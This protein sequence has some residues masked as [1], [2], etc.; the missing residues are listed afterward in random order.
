MSWPAV[1]TGRARRWHFLLRVSWHGA[2]YFFASEALSPSG[3]S[4]HLPSLAV[5]AY[6]ETFQFLSQSVDRQSVP[7]SVLW[8]GN[9]AAA[10]AA[11]FRL[12]T[13]EAELSVW[14]EGTA[15][16]S[17]RVLLVGRVMQPTY[18]APAEPVRFSIEAPPW[19]DQGTW[20]DLLSS[21][22]S[23]D[24]NFVSQ[25]LGSTSVGTRT[26]VLADLSGKTAPLVVG[27]PGN[28]NQ[29]RRTNPSSVFASQAP[30]IFG[31][32]RPGSFTS[33]T[34]GSVFESNGV[35]ALGNPA[36][37]F[38]TLLVLC[39]HATQAGAN[40]GDGTQKVRGSIGLE[41]APIAVLFNSDGQYVTGLVPHHATIGGRVCTVVNLYD[42]RNTRAEVRYNESGYPISTGSGQIT[43]L[44][45][46]NATSA[47]PAR[48]LGDQVGFTFVSAHDSH[49]TFYGLADP[50]SAGPLLYVQQLLGLVLSSSSLPVDWPRLFAALDRIPS[51]GVEGYI[52]ERVGV[53]EFVSR[54]L[55]PL[56]PMSLRTGPRGLYALTADLTATV[57]DTIGTLRAGADCWRVGGIQYERRLAD[58]TGTI[59][60]ELGNYAGQ[61]TRTITA[62]GST[63]M[64][65]LRA[66]LAQESSVVGRQISRV[67]QS[68][69]H[70]GQTTTTIKAPWLSGET[71]GQYVA[72]QHLAHRSAQIR[73]VRYQLAPEFLDLE[74]GDLVRLTDPEVSIDGPAYLSTLE[75]GEARIVGTF[76]LYEPVTR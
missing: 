71:G 17:R 11:G 10:V 50:K 51:F 40:G 61:P 23:Y 74:V 59:E 55:L 30:D 68:P 21:P 15:Y 22:K 47:D 65:G 76:S 75:I 13:S 37:T 33:M 42:Y 53:W 20:P 54:E 1:V 5:G 16:T 7:V 45:A 3:G 28:L 4:P 49:D 36:A 2:D 34:Y 41:D 24:A 58:L 26:R 38:D 6:S 29:T 32:T 9:I 72:H 73:T 43:P 66:R 18:G 12:D 19:V 8:P 44:V 14:V 67:Q 39:G 62:D 56:L 52:D 60:V 25:S 69:T 64:Q 70:S 46:T 27:N 57:A 63:M 35:T 31:S 48:I